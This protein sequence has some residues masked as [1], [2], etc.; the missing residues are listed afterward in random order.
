MKV[1][2]LV[3]R[4]FYFQQTFD[5]MLGRLEEYQVP[6][7]LGPKG[8]IRFL[9]IKVKYIIYAIACTLCLRDHSFACVPG[10]LYK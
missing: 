1:P 8:L 4:G 9:L 3:A 5:G 10:L 6:G 7:E 2:N